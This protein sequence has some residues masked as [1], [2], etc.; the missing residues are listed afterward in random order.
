MRH[1]NYCFFLIISFLTMAGSVSGQCPGPAVRTALINLQKAISNPTFYTAQNALAGQVPVSDTCGN[2]RYTRYV[3]IS[4]TC[5]TAN[6]FGSV[7]GLPPSTF[8]KICGTD[9]LFYIDWRREPV[10]LGEALTITQIL[11]SLQN[12][13]S[14]FNNWYTRNDTTTDLLRTASVLRSAQWRTIDSLGFLRWSNRPDGFDGPQFTVWQD[15]IVVDADTVLWRSSYNQP[16]QYH[17]FLA[18]GTY[19][20]MDSLKVGAWGQFPAFPGL[21][22]DGTEKGY[23]YIGEAAGIVHGDGTSGAYSRIFATF[24][25]EFDLFS[26]NPLGDFSQILSTNTADEQSV[27]LRSDQQLSDF[28]G[29]EIAILSDSDAADPDGVV[30]RHT[31]NGAN[32][33][34]LVSFGRGFVSNIPERAYTVTTQVGAVDFSWIQTVLPNDTTSQTISFYNR[35]YYFPNARPSNTLGDTSV[36]VWIGDGTNAGKQPQFVPLPGAGSTVNWYNSNGT[37]TDNTRIADVLE[38][39]TWRSDN[40]TQDGIVPFRFEIAG[41]GANEPENMVWA[42]PSG[43]SAMIYQADQEI[44][45]FSNN[46]LLSRSDGQV[47]WQADSVGFSSNLSDGA[48]KTGRYGVVTQNTVYKHATESTASTG[49]AQVELFLDGLGGSAVWVVPAGVVQN[50]KIHVTA[51]CTSAGN[52]VGISTGDAF[53]GW[54]LGGIKRVGSTTSL[55]GSVQNAATAQSDAGMSTSVVTIDADDTDESLRI[56]YTPPSTAGTTTVISIKASI[57]ILN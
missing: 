21:V 40:V 10:F 31:N 22:S 24:P 52:G 15:S 16:L 37:T 9:S 53:V 4:D 29:S 26:S 23:I 51:Y 11:D 35:A 25:G 47:N 8:I 45:L 50:F 12:D 6:P 18:D 49:T 46:N 1:K 36:I 54:Y 13:T 28:G 41:V 19:W 57:E 33:A 27:L 44:V 48:W 3:V 20:H 43:D 38:T 5:L 17:D 42:F 39:A 30:F 32:R 56:R 7:I 2:L 34:A 55:V 14:F